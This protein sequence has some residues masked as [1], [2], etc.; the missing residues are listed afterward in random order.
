VVLPYAFTRRR[1]VHG[2]GSLI[3]AP[4][5]AGISPSLSFAQQVAQPVADPWR[6]L[7]ALAGDAQ[8]LGIRMPP[9]ATVRGGTGFDVVMPATL[10]LIDQ[11]ETA[12]TLQAAPVAE[13]EALIDKASDLLQRINQA[14]RSPSGIEREESTRSAAA[15]ARP[16]F[17]SLKDEY[18]ELFKTCVI[19]DQN[20]SQAEDYAN[21][22]MEPK[23]RDQYTAA[24]DVPCLP[25]YF[26]GVIHALE[27]SF[28]FKAH[29]HNGDPLSKKTVQVPKGRPPVWN[30]PN[31]WVSSA[32]DALQYEGFG[33]QDD[34][35]LAR[36][37]YR[38]ETYNGF[39]SRTIYK[40][41]T[42]YLW[43]FSNHYT[44]GKFVADNVWDSNAVS[45]QCGAA[46][47]L[48][49]LVERGVVSMS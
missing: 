2:A 46:V 42:P 11:L 36:I 49:V 4:A 48:K 28:N 33:N 34:W 35:S 17:E 40:I 20:R 44:K 29:L 45:K 5:F 37:L 6:E 38:W 14:E 15:A 22:V 9:T 31:D 19:R 30:P 3:A 16:S 43:S 13:L 7:L 18:I 8:R 23:S 12:K 47:I 32:V 10:D 41:K 1:F 39:R 24:A 27:A 21:R 26:V 25:W